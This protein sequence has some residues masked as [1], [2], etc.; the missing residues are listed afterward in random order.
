M[1]RSAGK[2]TTS[3][4]KTTVV[5]DRRYLCPYCDKEKKLFSIVIPE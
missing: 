2:K 5:D 3:T 4:K 1:A